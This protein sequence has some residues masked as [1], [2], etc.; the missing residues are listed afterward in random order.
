[1]CHRG[2]ETGAWDYSTDTIALLTQVANEHDRQ[3]GRAPFREL[4]YFIA[5]TIRITKVEMLHGWSFCNQ[6]EN[7][8]GFRHNPDS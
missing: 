7:C 5:F 4:A 6:Y 3:F 1:M 2:N 8:H